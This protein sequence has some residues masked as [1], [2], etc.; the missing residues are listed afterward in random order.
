MS[1]VTLGSNNK[2]FFNDNPRENT[3]KTDMLEKNCIVTLQSNIHI[4]MEFVR[5]VICIYYNII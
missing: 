4:I 1:I 3:N 2:L 5:R